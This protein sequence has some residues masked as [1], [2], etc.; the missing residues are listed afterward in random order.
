MSKSGGTLINRLKNGK[1][2]NTSQAKASAIR[3]SQSGD[4]G[5]FV[6]GVTHR[7]M[8][9]E[10]RSCNRRSWRNG[11]GAHMRS[12]TWRERNIISEQEGN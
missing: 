7:T 1:E 5:A 9:D 12:E 3:D 4:G 6:P 10:T 11:F 2:G 8:Q